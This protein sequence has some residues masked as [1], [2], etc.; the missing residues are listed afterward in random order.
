MCFSR[1]NTTVSSEKFITLERFNQ[2]SK[3]LKYSKNKTGPRIESWGT[4][5]LIGQGDNS[6]YQFHTFMLYW[7]WSLNQFIIKSFAPYDFIFEN[8]ATW[9]RVS[10]S[11]DKSIYKAPTIFPLS[12]YLLI[13]STRY[14]VASSVSCFFPKSN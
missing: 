1:Y 4:P 12:I 8:K 14:K 9:L 10:K 7:T 5:H 6:D 13:L 3:L 2:F 11:F